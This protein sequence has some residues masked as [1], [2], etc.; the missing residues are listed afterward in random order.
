MPA[1]TSTAAPTP[2]LYVDCDVPEGMT[3]SEWRSHRRHAEDA[4]SR[5]SGLVRLVRRSRG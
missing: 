2:M 1:M 3:L 4:G 5:R